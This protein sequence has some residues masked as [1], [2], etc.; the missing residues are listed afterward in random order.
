MDH[1]S[2]I[3]KPQKDVLRRHNLLK[4]VK[5]I[6]LAYIWVS[7]CMTKKKTYVTIGSGFDMLKV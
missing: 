3:K 4:K 6:T 2:L 7:L 1:K 5:K